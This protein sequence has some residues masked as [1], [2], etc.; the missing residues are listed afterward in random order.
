MIGYFIFCGKGLGEIMLKGLAI[1]PGYAMGP[2]Y[3]LK[4]FPLDQV[5]DRSLAESDIDPEIARFSHALD[6]SRLEIRSLLDLPQIKSSL[7]IANIFQAH[8]TLLDDPDLHKEILKR[9]RQKRQNVEAVIGGVIKDYS[10]FFRN[11]P[12]PQFQGKAIDIIDVGQ[13]LLKNCESRSHGPSLAE[14]EESVVLVAD[15]LT[16]SDI[17]SFDPQKLIGLAMAEG[18][19]TSHASILAR[20]LGIPALIQVRALMQKVRP[21]TMVIIDGNTGVLHTNPDP[22]LVN[23]FRVARA[24]FLEHE[25]HLQ[26]N[27]AQPAITRDG[28]HITLCANIGQGKD[29]DAVLAHHADGVGLYRTEFAYLTHRHFPTEDEL[30]AAYLGVVRQLGQRPVVIRTI[31][32]GGDKISHLVGATQEKNPELG[33]RAVRMALD[34]TDIFRTQLRAILRTVTGAEHNNVK[35]LFPMISNLKELRQAKELLA[36]VAT[37]LRREGL[38]VPEKISTGAMIEVPSAALTVDKLAPEID[39]LSIGSNDL[40]QYTLAVDRTNSRV[41]HLYQPLNPA[42]LRLIAEV[43]ATADRLEKPV[44]ICGELAGDSRY[45]LLLLG[46]GLRELSMNAMFIPRVKEIVR[47]ASLPE[48]SALIA[49]IL[50]LDTAEE[51]ETA[52]L[53]LNHSFGCRPS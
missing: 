35:V 19:A 42:V 30:T 22:A 11:L 33:W 49:P 34:R 40:V 16:P 23:E 21:G 48:I 26:E 51:I 7:E 8:L 38:A 14:I 43:V 47:K 3:C 24:S 10:E 50:Q 5:P 32:L 25:R 6:I 15:D 1:S 18:T 36:E 45:T 4:Q 52:L 2:A 29:V 39:F 28:T 44:C 13:R 12:D 9:I 31:D 17:V 53:D 37:E 46:L 20:S 41:A 27:L